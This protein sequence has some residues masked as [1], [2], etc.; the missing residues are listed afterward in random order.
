MTLDET[1]LAI[2][3]A[4]G[5]CATAS[6]RDIARIVG[7]APVVV[8]DRIYCMQSAGVLQFR[9]ELAP[10]RRDLGIQALAL[11]QARPGQRREVAAALLD[12]DEVS[13]VVIL[14][15]VWDASVYLWCRDHSHLGLVQNK[16]ESI[17]GIAEVAAHVITGSASQ[18]GAAAVGGANLSRSDTV[19]PDSPQH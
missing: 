3:R 15:G 16:L 7:V 6:D 14:V 11:V 17:G 13:H 18:P 12:L 2:L 8:R 4:L 19:N 5:E 1:D 9:V 10:A